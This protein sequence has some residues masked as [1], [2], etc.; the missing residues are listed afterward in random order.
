MRPPFKKTATSTFVLIPLLLAMVTFSVR[1]DEM[2]P[3]GLFSDSDAVAAP[4]PVS[5]PAPITSGEKIA[6]PQTEVPPPPI[7]VAPSTPMIS[8]ELKL[9]TST[10]LGSLSQEEVQLLYR[11][12]KKSSATPPII[13]TPR[14]IEHY[15][16]LKSTC[17][18]A[19]R[20]FHTYKFQTKPVNVSLAVIRANAKKKGVFS[21]QL[22]RT[23]ATFLA[24]QDS[25]PNQ[26]YIT[27]IDFNRKATSKRMSI[28]D[29][30]DGSI[31]TWYVAHGKGSDLKHSGFP[32]KFDNIAHSHRSSLGCAIANGEGSYHHYNSRKRPNRF[33]M[34]LGFEKTND[35]MC[36]LDRVMHGA[37]YVG[38]RNGR[39]FGCP[40]VRLGDRKKIYDMIGNGGLVCSYSD[41]QENH[42]HTKA[43]NKKTVK[44]KKGKN[45]V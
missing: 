8:K 45:K 44:K 4:A 7:Y 10:P 23:L 38:P 29:L 1:A 39:S 36:Q 6:N 41:N 16:H 3:F 9:S 5:T 22:E 21:P 30:T 35:N 24:N 12:G 42:K 15:K 2:D 34:M 19:W 17:R 20:D 31:T 13:D 37:P 26:R 43:A 32:N 14:E 33:L 40:A 25:I 28:I 27:T 11:N 18:A